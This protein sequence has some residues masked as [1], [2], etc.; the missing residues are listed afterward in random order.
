MLYISGLSK[1]SQKLCSSC[2]NSSAAHPCCQNAGPDPHL[3]ALWPRGELRRALGSPL[4][5][6]NPSRDFG[7]ERQSPPRRA[8]LCGAPLGPGVPYPGATLHSSSNLSTA[9]VAHAS[10]PFMVAAL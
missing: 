4:Q 10:L 5:L 9:I 1:T 3:T 6:R 7:E 2:A 8:G